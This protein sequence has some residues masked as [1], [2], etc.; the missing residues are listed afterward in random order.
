MESRRQRRPGLPPDR[1]VSIEPCHNCG[2]LMR[3]ELDMGLNGNHIINC[4]ECGHEHCRVIKDGKVTGDRWGDR[5]A[6]TQIYYPNV[7]TFFVDNTSTQSATGNPIFYD[8]WVATT[9]V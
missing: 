1:V 4:P 6:P 8:S 3:F 7:T 9:V 5:N 2:S